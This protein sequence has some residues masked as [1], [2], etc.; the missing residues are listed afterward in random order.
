M[1]AATNH[2]NTDRLDDAE[3]LLQTIIKLNANFGRAYE[4]AA[5]IS[6][7]KG[8]PDTAHRLL[9]QALHY[10]PPKPEIHHQL[11]INFANLGDLNQSIKAQQQAIRLNP[12]F[13]KSYHHIG[14]ML[15]KLGKLEQA[16]QIFEK[17]LKQKPGY[18][19]IYFDYSIALWMSGNLEKALKICDKLVKLKPA[20]SGAHF[21]RGNVLM[22]LYR[23]PEAAAAFERAI[24][25]DPSQTG[26]YYNLSI[27]YTDLLRLD[28]AE[29][30][31]LKSDTIKPLN[32]TAH[33]NYLFLLAARQLCSVDKLRSELSNWRQS[34]CKPG[35]EHKPFNHSACMQN[36]KIRVGYVSY[37]FRSHSVTKFFEPLLKNHNKQEFEIFCYANHPAFMADLT[38]DRLRKLSDQWR[39]VSDLNDEALASLIHKDQIQILVDLNG[40]TS[41]NRLQTFAYRPAPVQASYLGYFG[42]T[43]VNEIDYWITDNILHPENTSEVAIESIFRLPR[44]W[45]AYQPPGETIKLEPRRNEGEG[46]VF[47]CFN[48]ASK[49]SEKLIQAWCVILHKLPNASFILMSKSYRADEVKKN[50]RKTFNAAG[51]NTDRLLFKADVSFDEYLNSYSSIDIIL[52]T[53]PRSGGTTTAEALWMGV[54]VVS[55]A[56]NTY[57]GRI[58][59]SKLHAVNMDE[60]VANSED[61]YI[62][63]AIDLAGDYSKQQGLRSTLRGKVEKS[64][65]CDAI[66]LAKAMENGYK[67]MLSKYVASLSS[68]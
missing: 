53:F 16:I 66:G 22:S 33:S 36:K 59:A 46:V 20:Q 29:K 38:T 24:R 62:Q 9:L 40:H 28:E 18:A 57:A 7:K 3:K 2:F 44:C 43:G 51:I 10:A 45:V 15:T 23:L 4:L 19:P 39:D 37:D 27:I 32:A 58:S 21:N 14:L 12:K 17:G 48:E 6:V 35:L 68:K 61:E 65:L 8:R 41:G 64:E 63:K 49:L 52:D 30:T 56:G 55:L 54:P 60:L 50:I 13:I 31:L 67:K 25:L 26:A 47:G 11:G 5:H 1:Q 34:H 42:S